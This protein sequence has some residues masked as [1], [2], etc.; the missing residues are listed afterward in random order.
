MGRTSQRPSYSW[1]RQDAAY[2]V[3]G[4]TLTVDGGVMARMALWF[5]D[6]ETVERKYDEGANGP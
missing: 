4:T 2:Y 3:T 1:R 6:L 5:D